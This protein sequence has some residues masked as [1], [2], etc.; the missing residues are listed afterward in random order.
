[1]KEIDP[2]GVG[3]LDQDGFYILPSGEFIDPEG[4]YFNEKGFDELGGTYDGNG[5]YLAP[6]GVSA[7]PDGKIY[8]TGP[9]EDD[10]ED[11]YDELDPDA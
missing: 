6:P 7:G 3:K 5:V 1:M 10:L 9:L 4:Y 11:Y 2:E 8:Y